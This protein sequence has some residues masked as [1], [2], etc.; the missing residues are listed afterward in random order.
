MMLPLH[1][2]VVDGGGFH[3]SENP[4]A[5]IRPVV[6]CQPPRRLRDEHQD[7]HHWQDTY[8]LQNNRDPPSVAARMGGECVID[9]VDEEDA[10]VEC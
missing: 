3:S 9:P 4:E 6:R 7:S 10:K 2:G 1:L 5:I 8:T